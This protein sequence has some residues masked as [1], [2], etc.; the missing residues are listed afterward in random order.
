MTFRYTGL[1]KINYYSW[2]HPFFNNVTSWVWQH[3]LIIPVLSRLR[4]DELE[5]KVSLG[6]I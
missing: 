1:K 2:F 6:Y 4:Q 5:L 3:M